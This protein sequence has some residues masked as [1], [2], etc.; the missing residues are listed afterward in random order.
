MP[1]QDNK[2]T[3]IQDVSVSGRERKIYEADL[4]RQRLR[5]TLYL[6]FQKLTVTGKQE[7]KREH[8]R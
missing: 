6:F 8:H 3:K 2:A 5:L 4:G 1:K 7:I